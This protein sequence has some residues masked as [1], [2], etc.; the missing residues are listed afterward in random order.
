M[1]EFERISNFEEITNDSLKKLK[2]GLIAPAHTSTEK[3]S[4]CETSGSNPDSVP[5][6]D[7]TNRDDI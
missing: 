2:G 6:F 4:G 1:S 3:R 7:S 5:D